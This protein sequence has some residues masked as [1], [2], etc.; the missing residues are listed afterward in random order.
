MAGLHVAFAS[1]AATILEYSLGG[2][3]MLHDLVKETIATEEGRIGVP[4]RP[5]LGVTPR[6]EFIDQYRV[7]I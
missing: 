2:N 4:Q 3:P 7:T 5:G 1:Q 6:Q